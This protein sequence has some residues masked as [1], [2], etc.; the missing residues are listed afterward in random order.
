VFHANNL[1]STNSKKI[2]AIN[3]ANLNDDAISEAAKAKK[4]KSNLIERFIDSKKSSSDGNSNNATNLTLNSKLSDVDQEDL[5]EI[6]EDNIPNKVCILSK[7][8][9]IQ[10]DK[11]DDPKMLS[12][13]ILHSSQDYYVSACIDESLIESNKIKSI[14][15]NNQLKPNALQKVKIDLLVTND[16]II[17]QSSNNSTKSNNHNNGND[18]SR[19]NYPSESSNN[20]NNNNNI[21]K[22]IGCFNSNLNDQMCNLFNSEKINLINKSI[23]PQKIT[24]NPRT[25]NHITTLSI[26]E[27]FFNDFGRC[28]SLN[29]PSSIS[30]RSLMYMSQVQM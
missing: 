18:R 20:N 26:N 29:L 13:F 22:N 5:I 8:P 15:N 3:K 30:H 9:S 16:C 25:N 19:L 4:L 27:S 21:G 17:K 24:K 12:V 10:E 1:N 23:P 14:L 11:I 6:I 7:L 28:D 2:E